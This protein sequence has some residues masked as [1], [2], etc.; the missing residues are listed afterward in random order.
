MF[1]YRV[2]GL[3]NYFD[4]FVLLY[5]NSVNSFIVI[6]QLGFCCVYILFV[7]KSIQQVK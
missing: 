5:R 6:T 1:M 4:M 7:S 2:I 3:T